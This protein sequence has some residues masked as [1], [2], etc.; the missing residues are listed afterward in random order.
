MAE[1]RG[2]SDVADVSL[3]LVILLASVTMLAG[4]LT[5]ADGQHDP[6]TADRV[7]DTLGASTFAVSYSLEP[8]LGDSEHVE[9]EGN[10]QRSTHG[11]AAGHVARAALG[12]ARFGGEGTS[13]RPLTAGREYRRALEE[14]LLVSLVGTTDGVNV[15][16][17]WEPF[18]GASVQGVVSL[19]E[20][21]PRGTD[22][23]LARL[24][25]ASELPSAAA[26]ARTGATNDGY[27]GVAR[28][29][30]EAIV[31]GAFA[32]ARRDLEAGGSRR[33][34]TLSRYRRFG[35][36]L[37]VGGPSD[38]PERSGADIDTAAM[39]RQLTEQLVGEFE[40]ELASSF[41][42]PRAAARAVSTGE[43]TVSVTTWER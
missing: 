3:A 21:P 11:T 33:A 24:T 14:R 22:T 8:V 15:T 23:S 38:G 30:A 10:L 6:E 40:P 7:A 5:A 41:D 12:G 42:T 29:V 28:A 2:I 1:E 26:A 36:A 43:V 35:T 13:N 39:D 9:A 31:G 16:A 25:V 20:R 37:G 27:T 32:G 19:G 34:I 4:Y 17:A 18:A